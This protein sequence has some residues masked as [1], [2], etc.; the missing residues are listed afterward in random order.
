[1][2]IEYDG[3]ECIEDVEHELEWTD[4]MLP[5]LPLLQLLTLY[6][7]RD[8]RFSIGIGAEFTEREDLLDTDSAGEGDWYGVA[9]VSASLVAFA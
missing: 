7:S 8:G 2:A 1:M 3:T 9:G 5:L 4:A 6:K